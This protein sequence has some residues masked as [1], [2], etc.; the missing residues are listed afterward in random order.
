MIEVGI[1]LVYQ[2]QIMYVFTI[3]DI[4]YNIIIQKKISQV[5]NLRDKW[6]QRCES[7]ARRFPDRLQ[8]GSR[9]TLG[10]SGIIKIGGRDRILTCDDIYRAKVAASDTHTTRPLNRQVY[11][12]ILE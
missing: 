9:W 1:Y 8:S 11:L 4:I 2:P 6:S 7:N 3:L 12:Q 10:Y 5:S